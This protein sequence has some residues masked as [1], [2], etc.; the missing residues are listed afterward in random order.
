MHTYIYLFYVSSISLTLA[1]FSR[2]VSS[3]KKMKILLLLL[4]IWSFACCCYLHFVNSFSLSNCAR[5]NF[6]FI[7]FIEWLRHKNKN[8]RNHFLG[9]QDKTKENIVL[10]NIKKKNS[11]AI[12]ID[13]MDY[14]LKLY[15]EIISEKWRRWTNK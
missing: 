12:K 9:Q 8:N 7:N 14:V 3:Q 10:M 15:Y 6:Y 11:N 13:I 2:L 1:L 4:L 5:R